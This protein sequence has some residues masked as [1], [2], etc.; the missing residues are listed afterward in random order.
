MTSARGLLTTSPVRVVL[1][2]PANGT[3]RRRLPNAAALVRMAGLSTRWLPDGRGTW[4]ELTKAACRT[5][6]ASLDAVLDLR[7]SRSAT[8]ARYR[9]WV[10]LR[11]VGYP[12]AVIAC[13][14]MVPVG[15]IVSATSGG[16]YPP[17]RQRTVGTAKGCEP[18]AGEERRVFDFWCATIAA[19]VVDGDLV[20]WLAPIEASSALTNLATAVPPGPPRIASPA[21]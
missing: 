20:A 9:A 18:R 1:R 16:L 7:R 6:G 14:W 5:E 13:V 11:K 2:A 12:Y 15:R 10:G 3:R 19:D 21:E 4:L 8:R 17:P